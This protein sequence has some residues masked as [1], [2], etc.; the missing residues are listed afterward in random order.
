M[1]LEIISNERAFGKKSQKSK[2]LQSVNLIIDGLVMSNFTLLD[3]DLS[4]Y[5]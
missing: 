4:I 2:P 1:A 5:I 3:T